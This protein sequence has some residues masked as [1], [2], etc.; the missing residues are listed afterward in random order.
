MK[1]INLF[2]T[3]KLHLNKD[4]KINFFNKEYYLI[5]AYDPQYSEILNDNE[6]ALIKSNAGDPNLFMLKKKDALEYHHKYNKGDSAN[7]KIILCKIPDE[8]QTMKDFEEA[9]EN[10]EIPFMDLETIKDNEL[11][12]KD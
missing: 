11:N 3:E 7:W 6:D 4:I 10:G 9:Y 8:Y 12:E 2:M 1:N 5:A